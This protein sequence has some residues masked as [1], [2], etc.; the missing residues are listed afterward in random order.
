M[1]FGPLHSKTI[2]RSQ[3]MVRQNVNIHALRGL[4][5]C[6]IFIIAMGE[7][8]PLELELELDL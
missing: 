3:R 8:V 1:K 5:Y 2:T 7:T 4:R 6:L